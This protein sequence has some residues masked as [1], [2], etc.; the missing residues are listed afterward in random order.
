MAGR[1]PDSFIHDLLARTDIVELI[2]TRMELKRAGREL[3]GLSPFTNE[4][5]PSFHV[6]PQ[7]QMFFDFSS[8]K[9][10]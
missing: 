10:G 4:K 5:T 7:K 1:I 3:K 9:N 2:G 6:N 8:G